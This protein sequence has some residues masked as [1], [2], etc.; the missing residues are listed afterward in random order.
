VKSPLPTR[1][2]PDK[3]DLDQLKRQAR[4]L[5]EAFVGGEPDAERKRSASIAMPIGHSL[6]STT[7][8]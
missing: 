8:N 4:E 2:L 7:P 6:R 5:L 1:H 3:P